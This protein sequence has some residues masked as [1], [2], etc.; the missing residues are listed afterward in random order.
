MPASKTYWKSA[1]PREARAWI[2]SAGLWLAALLCGCSQAPQGP[3][4]QAA[5]IAAARVYN[6]E[7]PY[8]PRLTLVEREGDPRR[9]LALAVYVGRSALSAAALSMLVEGRIRAAGVDATAHPSPSGFI[10]S[11]L[12]ASPD[13]VATFIRV[14]NGAL[15]APVAALDQDRVAARWRAAAPRRASSPSEAAIAQCS[16][17]LLLAPAAEGP[18]GFTSELAQWL[19][20][21]GVR[22]VAFSVVGSKEYLEAG[23][24]ALAALTPWTRLTRSLD[25][26]PTADLVGNEPGVA[27]QLGL[28][29]ALWGS[30][31]AEA[32]ATAERLADPA[33]LLALRLGAGFPAWQVARIT[34][35]LNRG[36]ACLRVD[37]Q[38]TGTSPSIGAVAASISDAF[39]EIEHTLARVKPGPWVVAKQVLAMD[40]P[41]QAAAVAAW[42]ALNAPEQGSPAA[43]TPRRLVH[44]AGPLSPAPRPERVAQ[45]LVADGEP[46]SAVPELERTIE[47]GQGKFWMLLASPCGTRGEDTSSAG[48]LALMLQASA[49]A[50]D[51]R[52]GVALE[53]WINADAMG[54]LAH[55]A[56]M[57]PHESPAA[58]A[59]RVAEAIARAL[60]TVGPEPMAIAKARDF[61]LDGLADG[62]TPTLSLALRQTSANRPSWLEPRGTWATL[63]AISTRSVQV[64]RESFVRGKLRLASLGNHDDAQV[65]AG[66]R[67]LLKLLGSM[68]AGHRDC[69]ARRAAASIA[70]K[71]V[72]QTSGGPADADA[73]ISVPLPATQGL[74]QEALWTEWLMNRSGGWLHQALLR[75]GLVSTAR[76]RAMGGSG[77]AAL[78]IE[79]HAIDG[80][81]EEAVAQ[82]RGLLERLRAGAATAADARQA[83]EFLA[84]REMQRQLNPRGRLVDLWR[85]TSRPAPTLRSLHALHR[86]AFEA[87][88]EVVVLAD[89]PD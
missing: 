86:V 15:L 61:L 27:G 73:V 29:V 33:S 72:I 35:N 30:A 38:A 46:G 18:S 42:Q 23:A 83:G 85:G 65:D 75:P 63:S 62:P 64:E 77:S 1:W 16:G 54:L 51:N 84:R 78:V 68:G 74:P 67:R 31:P 32:M 57:A 39:D 24:K 58:Q 87:G 5:A 11:A 2:S 50:F 60:L 43:D 28:S 80:K 40:A 7:S 48:T 4:P 56:A 79:I 53:P 36:G 49:L 71:Y 3:G 55:S 22:D 41:H 17:E 13:D 69:A 76:A 82:V 6:Q 89:P 12:A 52:A 88:R 37:L 34:G 26:A 25:P 70:G 44:Y 20:L 45:L 14:A 66:E 19:A 10:L 47:S 8:R 9:G 59:E 21:I 81:R